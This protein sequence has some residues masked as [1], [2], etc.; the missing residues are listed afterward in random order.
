MQAFGF[1]GVIIADD[2]R[3]TQPARTPAKR[4]V[5]PLPAKKVISL[6]GK[7][8][9]RLIGCR[10]YY[11]FFGGIVAGLIYALPIILLGLLAGAVLSK[12]FDPKLIILV[13]DGSGASAW[14][15]LFTWYE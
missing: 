15:S 6:I 10:S 3:S 5:S 1:Q 7:A 8:L 4:S 9:L 2:E 11:C 13:D 12:E 14:V